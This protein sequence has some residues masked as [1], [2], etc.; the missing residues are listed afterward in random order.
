MT[1]CDECGAPLED[2]RDKDA[3]GWWRDR[4]MECIEAAAPDVDRTPI[5]ISD[6]EPG[7]G[8]DEQ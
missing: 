4:C 8:G 1:D 2:P 7:S 3:G 6:F 5:D